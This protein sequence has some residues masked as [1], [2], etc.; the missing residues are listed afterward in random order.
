MGWIFDCFPQ[1]TD[2]YRGKQTKN[3]NT[4]VKQ[5]S[6]GFKF[7]KALRHEFNCRALGTIIDISM[8]P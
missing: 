7:T 5:L 6:F 8:E 3:T 1:K 4:I 2:R